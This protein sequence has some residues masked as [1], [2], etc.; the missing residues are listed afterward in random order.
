MTHDRTIKEKTLAIN[1]DWVYNQAC[2][3]DIHVVSHSFLAFNF[4]FK[5][6]IKTRFSNNSFKVIKLSKNIGSDMP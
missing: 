4:L 3:H 1:R 5:L 2:R 6:I